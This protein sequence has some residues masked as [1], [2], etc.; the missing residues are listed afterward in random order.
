MEPQSH[1]G[2]EGPSDLRV[3]LRGLLGEPLLFPTRGAGSLLLLRRY[4]C[5]APTLLCLW[6]QG[7]DSKGVGLGGGVLKGRETNY[8][9]TVMGL[10]S[11]ACFF[12]LSL[13]PLS[14]PQSPRPFKI[15]RSLQLADRA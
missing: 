5:R 8:L 12:P 6:A 14:L 7:A 1:G 15:E 11:L 9:P 2:K 10:K 4:D 3:S 13:T